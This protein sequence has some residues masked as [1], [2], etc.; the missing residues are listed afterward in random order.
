[1]G[2]VK[3]SVHPITLILGCLSKVFMSDLYDTPICIIYSY[4]LKFWDYDYNVQ[5]FYILIRL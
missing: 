2:W 3:S 5:V 1:M 4:I